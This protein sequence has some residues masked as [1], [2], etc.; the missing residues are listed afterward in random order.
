MIVIA[1]T[2][3]LIDLLRGEPRAAKLR[4]A[5]V[6]GDDDVWSVTVVRTEILAG[7]RP[8]EK[9][10]TMALLDALKWQDITV[11]VADRAGALARRYLKSHP[12][13][14]TIDYLIASATQLLGGKLLTQNVKH[15]P[16]FAGLKPAY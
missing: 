14:D 16:M 8:K 1:D 10:A 15:F 3:V 12:G 6:S 7:M 5:L 9:R 2:C 4:D 13:V 11:D